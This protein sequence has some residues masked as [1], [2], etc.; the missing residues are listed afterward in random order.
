MLCHLNLRVVDYDQ[1]GAAVVTCGD[2][3]TYSS[4]LSSNCKPLK[5]MQSCITTFVFLQLMQNEVAEE[6]LAWDMLLE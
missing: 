6:M 3:A 1:L 4:L 2:T 5:T